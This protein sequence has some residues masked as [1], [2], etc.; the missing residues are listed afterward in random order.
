MN[1]T[2]K[3]A[4]V[5]TLVA[6]AMTAAQAAKQVKRPVRVL[7]DGKAAD[8]RPTKIETTELVKVSTDEVLGFKDYGTHVVVV[9]TDG[10]KFSSAAA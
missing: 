8:G 3:P 6:A 1:D 10:Q 5:A 4:A 2:V 7:A 9:T